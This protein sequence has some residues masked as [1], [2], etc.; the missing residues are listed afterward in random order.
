MRQ[1]RRFSLGRLLVLLPLL[2]RAS[3]QPCAAGFANR[4]FSCFACQQGTYKSIVGSSPCLPC[5]EGFYASTRG[6]TTCASCP[7]NSFSSS[8]AVDASSCL[9]NKGYAASFLG[10]ECTACPAGT[11]KDVSGG[12]PCLACAQGT[13]SSASAAECGCGPGYTRAGG[14]GCVAC[15][16]GSYKIV[17]STAP[18]S[19]CPLSS[20]SLAGAAFCDCTARTRRLNSSNIH[21][22]CLGPK[23]Q[24]AGGRFR[25]L[26]ININ[27]SMVTNSTTIMKYR[28]NLKARLADVFAIQVALV[29]IRKM[30]GKTIARQ[31]TPTTTMKA[32]NA[33]IELNVTG[34]PSDLSSD[35]GVLL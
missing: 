27:M 1:D 19:P 31:A 14:Q 16:A 26:T 9:C 35:A 7:E 12:A 34:D 10:T 3:G 23:K 17:N 2:K 8:N 22:S 18:C 15:A 28:E 6:A 30:T 25:R 21:S 4:N 32:Y 24:V 13:Y 29:K 33:S 20:N 11:Y 5:E